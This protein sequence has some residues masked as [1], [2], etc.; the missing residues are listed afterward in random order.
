MPAIKCV[1]EYLA[2]TKE[3]NLVVHKY[4]QNGSAYEV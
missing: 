3:G 1:I 4:I 2:I